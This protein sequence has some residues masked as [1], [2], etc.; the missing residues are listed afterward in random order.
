M[1]LFSLK[2]AALAALSFCSLAATVQGSPLPSPSEV[3][4]TIRQ[5]GG[6]KNI[7]YF[8]NWVRYECHLVLKNNRG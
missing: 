4:V 2:K 5:S 8:T 6:Y 3:E 7:V 1:S